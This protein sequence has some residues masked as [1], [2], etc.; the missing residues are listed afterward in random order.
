MLYLFENI[1]VNNFYINLKLFDFSRSEIYILFKMEG[2]SESVSVEIRSASIIRAKNRKKRERP[3]IKSVW[4]L[5]PRL[6][7]SV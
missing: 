3:V 2:V 6:I 1:N 5:R 7:F 4:E